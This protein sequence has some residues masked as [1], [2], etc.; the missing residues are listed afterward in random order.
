MHLENTLPASFFRFLTKFSLV[1]G[2]FDCIR[3]VPFPATKRHVGKQPMLHGRSHMLFMEC[4]HSIANKM[5]SQQTTWA[6]IIKQASSLACFGSMMKTWHGRDRVTSGAKTGAWY[7][8]YHH[9]RT[10][11][12]QTGENGTTAG[13]KNNKENGAHYFLQVDKVIWFK[14]GP[15]CMLVLSF[16]NHID[17]NKRTRLDGLPVK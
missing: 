15:R 11:S 17:H 7:H 14:R 4:G 5:A 13:H 2:L 12:R 10:T 9:T 1:V 8:N 6:H 3:C 16:Y